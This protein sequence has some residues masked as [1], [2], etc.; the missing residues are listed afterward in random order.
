MLN[1]ILK[2]YDMIAKKLKIYIYIY[3][4]FKSHKFPKL[5]FIYIYS[6]ICTYYVRSIMIT[7]YNQAKMPKTLIGFLV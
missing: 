5:V 4:Y 1:Y 2:F 3:I 6:K 7:F